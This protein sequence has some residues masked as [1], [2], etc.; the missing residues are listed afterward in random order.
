MLRTGHFIVFAAPAAI[1]SKTLEEIK[2]QGQPMSH[3]AY[4]IT[5]VASIHNRMAVHLRWQ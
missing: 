1:P 2:L 3:A 5:S 4:V